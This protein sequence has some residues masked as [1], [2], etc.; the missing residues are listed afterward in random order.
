M[1]YMR[2]Y[3]DTVFLPQTNFSLQSGEFDFS[4]MMAE[5]D[6]TRSGGFIL[7]DGPPYA[8]GNTHFG[9]ALNKIAKDIIARSQGESFCGPYWRNHGVGFTPGWDCHGLPIEWAVERQL[10]EEGKS[11]S[12]MSVGDFRELCREFA[13][14]WV[15]TQRAQFMA[16]GVRADWSNPYLTMDYASEAKVVS[17]LHELAN[18][19]LLYRGVKPVQWSVVEKTALAENEVEFHDLKTSQVWVK[20]PIIGYVFP[21]DSDSG[22]LCSVVIWTTTPWTIPANRAIAYNPKI[23]YGMYCAMRVGDASEDA[24]YLILADK[25][26][27]KVG[28]DAGFDFFERVGSVDPATL[29][30][31]CHPFSSDDDPGWPEYGLWHKSPLIAGDHVSDEI[32]TGFVHIAPDHGPDDF[33]LWQKHRLGEFVSLI[34]ADGTYISDMPLFGGEPVLQQTPKGNWIFEYCNAKIIK[35]LER[36]GNLLLT[37]KASHS[38][39]HSWRSKAPL[40]YRTTPQWFLNVEAIRGETMTEIDSIT[41]IPDHSKNRFVAALES[42]P[43]WLISRQRVWGTPMALIVHRETGKLLKSAYVERRIQRVLQKVGG[44]AWWDYPLDVFLEGTDLNPD[45]YEKVM[46]VLD[47]WFDSGC[48]QFFTGTE[49]AD[50][51]IEGSDQ[52]RGWFGSSM[53]VHMGTKGFAPFKTLITH[54]F[55]LDSKKQKLSKSKIESEKLDKKPELTLE[56]ALVLYGADVVRLWVAMSDNT[57][58]I[59]VSEEIFKTSSEMLKRFRNT[60]R[61]LMGNLSNFPHGK[62][63]MAE[64]FPELEKYILSRMADCDRGVRAAYAAFDSKEVCKL[65]MEFCVNDLSAFYFDIRKDVLYC[66][67]ETSLTRRACVNTMH[68]LFVTLLR[69]LDPLVPFTVYEALANTNEWLDQCRTSWGPVTLLMPSQIEDRGYMTIT[70]DVDW[71]RIREI[72]GMVNIELEK[73]R[74]QKIIRSSLEAKVTVRT[75]DDALFE[76]L[77]AA[78]LFRVSQAVID[79]CGHHRLWETSVLVVRAEGTKCARSW[80][81]LP[82]IGQDSRHPTLSPRDAEAVVEYDATHGAE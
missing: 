68:A 49:Q 23:S 39:A 5:L 16:L 51:Y 26:A 37:V 82:S 56:R 71:T 46:D 48:S 75:P 57:S 52:H 62:E 4:G 19:D 42:R 79:P 15:D 31:P 35:E 11:K 21:N 44:D 47:V 22:F 9:H 10:I 29:N 69:W 76:K 30:D 27:E 67:P 8:N 54:G 20:F 74:S 60:L 41:F 73:A 2:D 78:D 25:L 59:Q 18:R 58:D 40:I 28:S 72:I 24:E 45:D 38:Y 65:I 12:D 61:F 17:V 81:I 7:H 50:V 66:D 36:R 14:K 64:N 13:R 34:N 80:K 53:L 77:D 32:G 1:G 6:R 43:D 33:A 3:K 55:V 70:S 63:C